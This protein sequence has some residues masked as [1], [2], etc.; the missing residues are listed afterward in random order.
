MRLGDLLQAVV[1]FVG[2]LMAFGIAQFAILNL[3]FVTVS[4]VVVVAIAREYQKRTAEG[5]SERA[6]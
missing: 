2:T 5:A 4:L 1:V 3:V 6:A